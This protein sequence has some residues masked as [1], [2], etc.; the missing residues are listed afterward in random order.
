MKNAK[1]FGLNEPLA[2]SNDIRKSARNNT[3]KKLNI[4][5]AFESIIELEQNTQE[6]N[7]KFDP[8]DFNKTKKEK[9]PFYHLPNYSQK[10]LPIFKTENLTIEVNKNIKEKRRNITKSIDTS[11]KN[12]SKI[13]SS[14]KNL[15][16][17]INSHHNKG[18]SNNTLPFIPLNNNYEFS[19]KI[20]QADNNKN[21]IIN[22]PQGKAKNILH[23]ASGPLNKIKNSN[24]T[25]T[26]PTNKTR[27]IIHATSGPV[28]NKTFQ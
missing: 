8:K 9:R 21:N 6:K 2:K 18:K 1:T 10:I 24:P 20:F 14:T 26:E 17:G 13:S 11:A 3:L 28:F 15:F 5:M 12:A 23:A 25:S 19:T 27:N 7:V 4:K 22:I 16:S